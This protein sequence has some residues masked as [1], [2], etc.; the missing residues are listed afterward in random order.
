MICHQYKYKQ[1]TILKYN[2]R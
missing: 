1:A 2:F